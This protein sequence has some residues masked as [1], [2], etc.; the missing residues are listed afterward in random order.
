LD[1]EPKL[2]ITKF[3]K[4]LSPGIANNVDL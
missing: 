4:G 2:K 3:I 1:E